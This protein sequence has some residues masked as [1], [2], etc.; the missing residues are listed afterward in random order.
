MAQKTTTTTTATPVTLDRELLKRQNFVRLARARMTVTLKKLDSIMQLSHRTAYS[1][2]AAQV[3]KIL[4]ALKTRVNDIEAA[5]TAQ[6]ATPK[7]FDL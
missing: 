3:D 1:Y 7:E 6:N 5:F 2:D 4:K